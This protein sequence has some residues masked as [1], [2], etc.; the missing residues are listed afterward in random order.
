MYVRRILCAAGV[1]AAPLAPL[2]VASPASAGGS[3]VVIEASFSGNLTS[4]PDGHHTAVNFNDAATG[5]PADWSLD[6]GTSAGTP[7]TPRL[8]GPAG[9]SL[10]VVD[11]AASC[12]NG[13]GGS[14]VKVAVR[15]ADGTTIGTVSYL[16]L[17]DIAVAEGQ[18][19]ATDTVLGVVGGDFA[20]DSACWT[21]PHLH[22]EGYNATDYSC[23]YAPSTVEPGAAIGRIGGSDV[24]ARVSA[25]P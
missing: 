15:E 9:M 1:A 4:H 22:I 14:G 2:V 11:V 13:G 19:I 20:V 5:N 17:D 7:V 24:G 3:E 21:G 8:A 23:Y 12:K 18:A 10:E 16:H 6:Y 25:C